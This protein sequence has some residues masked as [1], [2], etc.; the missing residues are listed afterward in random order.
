MIELSLSHLRLGRANRGDGVDDIVAGD[1]VDD[2][3]RGGRKLGQ[4]APAVRQDD[5]VGHLETLDPAGVRISQGGL[6]DGRADDRDPH[7]TAQVHHDGLPHRLREGVDVSPAERT[8]P[9]R[10]S[11]DQLLLDPCQAP[12]LGVLTGGQVP[13]PAV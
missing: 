9:L 6:H 11:G 2:G 3:V 12:P 4:L 7:V 8:G 5:R 13:G 10:A 1:D